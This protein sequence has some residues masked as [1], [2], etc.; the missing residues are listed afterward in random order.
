M[1]PFSLRSLRYSDNNKNNTLNS[2]GNNGHGLENVTC[3]QTLIR[4]SLQNPDLAELVSIVVFLF[5]SSKFWL[6]CVW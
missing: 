2:G 1:I 5:I 3:K 6:Q 4:Q